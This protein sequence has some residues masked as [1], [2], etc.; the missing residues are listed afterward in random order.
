MSFV[1]RRVC[2]GVRCWEAGSEALEERQDGRVREQRAR[3]AVRRMMGYPRRGV[4]RVMMLL[5]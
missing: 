2:W 5:M 3:K 1:Y 4:A